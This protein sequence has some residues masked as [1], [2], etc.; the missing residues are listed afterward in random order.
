MVG[1]WPAGL[2]KLAESDELDELLGFVALVALVASER[3]KLAERG[4]LIAGICWRRR[5]AVGKCEEVE[6]QIHLMN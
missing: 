4:K 5:L 2:K 6:I 3:E 1:I